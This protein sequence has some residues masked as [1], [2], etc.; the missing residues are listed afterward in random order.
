[1]SIDSIHTSEFKNNIGMSHWYNV[2]IRRSISDGD[3]RSG[4]MSSTRVFD[5]DWYIVGN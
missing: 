1:M 3:T 5:D 2:A 4:L